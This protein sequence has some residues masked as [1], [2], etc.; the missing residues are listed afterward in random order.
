VLSLFEMIGSEPTATWYN[1]IK[2]YN[3]NQGGFSMET[4][5]FTQVV[6]KNSQ[7]LGAG[8]AYTN[9]GRSAYVVAQY[10][11]PGNYGNEYE[12]N[13]FPAQC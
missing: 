1:G 9:D 13:V 6:W 2:Y 7:Q 12:E 4:G 5:A 11:P 8:I 10:L 3:F